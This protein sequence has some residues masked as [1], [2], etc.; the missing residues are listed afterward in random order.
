MDK[1]ESKTIEETATKLFDLLGIDEPFEV[2]EIEEGA[3]VVI[4]ATDS[5]V[6]IGRHGENLEGLQLVLSLCVSQKLGEFKRISVEVGDYKKKREEW[7][8]NLAVQTKERAL[9]ENREI[10]LSNLKSW[11]RRIVHIYLQE[12]GEVVSESMGEGKDRVLIVKP[13]N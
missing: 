9:S 12:D 10:A 1:N 4:N 3:E 2:K 5:G 6:I 8:T 13:K 7:L 11:E